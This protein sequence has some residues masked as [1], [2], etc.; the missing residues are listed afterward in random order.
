MN[1][2][3]LTSMGATQPNQLGKML[4]FYLV[5]VLVQ[6]LSQV[7]LSSGDE[8]CGV[9]RLNN[10]PN[11]N[12]STTGADE[13]RDNIKAFPPA[14]CYVSRQEVKKDVQYLGSSTE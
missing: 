6:L 5:L 9:Q 12:P 7:Y 1:T 3:L 2:Y 11:P 4:L 8:F 13:A 10:H 14:P